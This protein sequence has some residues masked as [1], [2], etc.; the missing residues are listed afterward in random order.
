ML[1]PELANTDQY[2]EGQGHDPV[3]HRR[4]QGVLQVAPG[5]GIASSSTRQLAEM[6]EAKSDPPLIAE[7]LEN[8]QAFTLKRFGGL[9]LS[10]G[11]KGSA[12]IAAPI[13]QIP[14]NISVGK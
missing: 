1:K 6:A 7:F 8:R 13:G 11:C 5:V 9:I 14:A 3:H 10:E 4:S 12:Q 2:I